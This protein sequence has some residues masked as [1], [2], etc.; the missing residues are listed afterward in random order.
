MMR[1]REH[2]WIV[3]CDL[4][5]ILGSERV[6]VVFSVCFLLPFLF[7]SWLFWSCQF[8]YR[9]SVFVQPH[10]T[11]QSVCRSSRRVKCTPQ[12][13]RAHQHSLRLDVGPGALSRLNSPVQVYLLR[14]RSHRG[15]AVV[16]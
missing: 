16:R 3:N 9:V 10:R 15:R 8:S 12:L 1:R 11:A 6:I 5:E 13:R 7:I 4:W 2:C 14:E